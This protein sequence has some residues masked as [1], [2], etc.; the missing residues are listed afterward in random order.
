MI[1]VHSEDAMDNNGVAGNLNW[2][3]TLKVV[4]LRM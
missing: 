2:I 3:R 1:R 4:H